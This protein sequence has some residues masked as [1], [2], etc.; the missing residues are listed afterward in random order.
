MST[1][2]SDMEE[3][4][5]AAKA[6]IEK[7]RGLSLV[8]DEPAP[9]RG[10][11]PSGWVLG[12]AGLLVAQTLVFAYFMVGRGDDTA[13]GAAAAAS[14]V[15]AAGAAGGSPRAQAGAA[16]AIG[17]A[18]VVLQAQGFVVARRQATVSTRVAGIVTEVPV[19]V[20][21]YVERGQVV[22]VLNSDLAEKDLQLAE[23]ELFSLRSMVAREQ[24]RKDQ[25][26]SEYRRELELEKSHYTSRARV[27][28]KKAASIVASTSLASTVA[29]LDLGEVRVRQQRSLLGN[30]TIRAPFSGIVVERNSQVGELVA[31]MSAGGSFTRTG[32]CTIV[33]MDSLILVVDVGEQQI[34]NVKVGQ[35]VTFRLYSDE[36][37]QMQGKVQR[38]VPSADRAKGTLQVQIV[39]VGKDPRVL[40]GMRANVNFI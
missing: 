28:E 14:A 9:A 1:A 20:G 38:I 36:Q 6:R 23:K 21:D 15:G 5:S 37:T 16:A 35:S 22:G 3:M 27:D 4:N 29:E 13:G 12:L 18:N 10:K 40:P 2:E 17:E 39:I 19:D 11:R 34:Q 7:I 33:D 24:A 32:I 25:A 8:R 26:E 30:Y 31:P